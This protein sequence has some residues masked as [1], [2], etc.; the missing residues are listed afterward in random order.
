MTRFTILGIGAV[1]VREGP[2]PVPE[3]REALCSACVRAHIESG[4]EPGQERIFCTLGGWL[5]TPDFP[6]RECT[7][8]VAIREGLGF[9]TP[10]DKVTA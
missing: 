8:Y 6:V 10:L 2:A 4:F 9:E 7:S 3:R 5:R 1:A